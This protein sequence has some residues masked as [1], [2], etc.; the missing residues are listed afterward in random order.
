MR[1]QRVRQISLR[2][3][4]FSH[5]IS[6]D[7]ANIHQFI[8]IARRAK[9]KPVQID[10]DAIE[11]AEGIIDRMLFLVAENRDALITTVDRVRYKGLSDKAPIH[12]LQE[13]RRHKLLPPEMGAVLPDAEIGPRDLLKG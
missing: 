4:W 7:P 6:R 8:G 10:A 1:G 12:K 3:A 5:Q 13:R 2:I 11:H 9:A